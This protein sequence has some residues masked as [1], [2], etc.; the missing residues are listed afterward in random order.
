MVNVRRAVCL[1]LA[2]SGTP[3]ASSSEKAPRFSVPVRC[4]PQAE[5]LVQQYLDLSPGVDAVDPF[6][7]HAT[8]DGHNG[9]DIRVPSLKDMNRGVPIS[10]MAAGR[11]LRS[12]DGQPDRLVGGPEERKAL[13]GKECGN[14]LVVD[15][16]EGWQT[17]YCHMKEGSLQV[18]PG[19]VVE[20]GQALGFI[21]TSGLAQFPHLHITFRHNN[22]VMDPQTGLKMG[23]GCVASPSARNPLWD[24]QAQTWLQKAGR[25]TINVGLTGAVHPHDQLVRDGAPPELRL[26][27]E[28]V[29]GWGWFV[30]LSNGDRVRVLIKKPGG[31]TLIDHTS[32]PLA[33]AKATY[34]EFAGRKGP[35]EA[36]HYVVS[37]EILRAGS[38][39]EARTS[40]V[41]VS[42]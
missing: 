10:A 26:S 28:A 15:H 3:A 38:I 29:V 23:G 40:T 5:C 9:T 8:Y 19:Q 41:E 2:V 7:G 42:R 27:D 13:A 21:G 20:R 33:G 17:Q 31:A 25:L 34:S 1:F 18:R 37:V 35:V 11:V 6:C 32:Q 39:V 22:V 12:R 16:G 30:N 24:S 14:G 4:D 36:G